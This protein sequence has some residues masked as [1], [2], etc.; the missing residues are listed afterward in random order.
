M[1]HQDRLSY[2]S[3]SS[4]TLVF[5]D[6]TLLAADPEVVFSS[7]G[8]SSITAIAGAVLDELDQR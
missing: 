4:S 2:C 7:V 5:S 8:F 6:S 3:P 1:A